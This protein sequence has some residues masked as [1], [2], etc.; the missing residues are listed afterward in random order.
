MKRSGAGLAEALNGGLINESLKGYLP[1]LRQGSLRSIWFCINMSRYVDKR[2]ATSASGHRTIV[3]PS[4][5]VQVNETSV[6]CLEFN[7]HCD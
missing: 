5:K 3:V 4:R 6:M 2:D 7:L 1:Q